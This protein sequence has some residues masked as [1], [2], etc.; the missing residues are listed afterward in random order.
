MRQHPAD[1]R[2]PH[3]RAIALRFTSIYTLSVPQC[4][5]ILAC[6][7]C[8]QTRPLH[9]HPHQAPVPPCQAPSL[10]PPASSGT[11]APRLR[12]RGRLHAKSTSR[13]DWVLLRLQYGHRYICRGSCKNLHRHTPP[14]PAPSCGPAP[15]PRVGKPCPCVPSLPLAAQPPGVARAATAA[16]SVSGSK[17]Q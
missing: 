15:R 14:S 7:A 9:L 17:K 13:V 4:L 8:Q 1:G 5:C 11:S 10:P 3:L 12:H 16:C 6:H 2:P